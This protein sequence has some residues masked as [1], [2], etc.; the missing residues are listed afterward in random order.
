LVKPGL[1]IHTLDFTFYDSSFTTGLGLWIVT[2]VT[3]FCVTLAV[4]YFTKATTLVVDIIT[5]VTAF[6]PAGT[7]INLVI[8]TGLTG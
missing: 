7:W 8:A 3:A 2:G 4:V 6:L 1:L 5:G